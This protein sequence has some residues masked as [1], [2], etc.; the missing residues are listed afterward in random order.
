MT[1]S[2]EY[3][4]T[5]HNNPFLLT[6]IIVK[7]YEEYRGKQPKDI[8]LSY[9]ILAICLYDDSK[10]ILQRKNKGRDL[11]TFINYSRKEDLKKHKKEITKNQKLF[12]LP[13]RINEYKE[14]TNLCLQY[15]LDR[16]NLKVNK[17]LSISFVKNDF[18]HDNTLTE[19]IK[20]SENLALMLKHEKLINIYI[21]L[22]I[23]N[24]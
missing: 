4:Y 23:K 11:R 10:R 24:L 14:M 21:K 20:A 9:L 15:A 19:F 12:G 18:A 16:G 5:L 8:L 17:D 22:G 7:F 13:D 1:K 3:L 2:V 6:P